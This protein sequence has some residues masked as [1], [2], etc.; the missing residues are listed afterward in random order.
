MTAIHS[1]SGSGY[2]PEL[3]INGDFSSGTGWTLG[4]GWTIS[5][6]TAAYAASGNG[7]RQY[8]TDSGRKWLLTYTINSFSGSGMYVVLFGSST[9]VTSTTQTSPG[10]YTEVLTLTENLAQVAFFGGGSTAVLDNASV[11]Q[12]R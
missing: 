4:A 9:S 11:K 3:L 2:G 5:G 8:P 7:M 12:V 6:G 1:S 10:T